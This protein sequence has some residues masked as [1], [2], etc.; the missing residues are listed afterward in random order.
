MGSGGSKC[1]ALRDANEKIE[2]ALI[3]IAIP[4]NEWGYRCFDVPPVAQ[5]M[6]VQDKSLNKSSLLKQKPRQPMSQ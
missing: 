3:Y 1:G 2:N 5:T 6:K 4:K